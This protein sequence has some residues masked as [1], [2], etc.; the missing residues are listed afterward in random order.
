MRK[1]LYLSIIENLKKIKDA[2][3]CSRFRHFNL[4]N[5]QVVFLE[6]GEIFELPAAFIEFLPI[7]WKQTNSG[8][9]EA[10]VQ[11]RI[12]IVT[13]FEGSSA[14]GSSYQEQSLM[15]F[16]LLEQVN[17]CLTGI[18]GENFRGM[19][20][21]ESYTNHNHEEVIESIEAFQV[22]VTDKSGKRNEPLP[23]WA[24]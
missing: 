9:Q 18:S 5:E 12:H 17:G 8:I 20:R 13:K 15:L 22:S 24:R 7:R 19:F 4:W 23:A 1:Q 16:D 3:G 14:D 6:Q 21:T 2:K 11:F 10:A